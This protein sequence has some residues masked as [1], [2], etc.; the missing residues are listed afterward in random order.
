MGSETSPGPLQ[1]GGG[2]GA[3][4]PAYLGSLPA[5]E[6]SGKLLCLWEPEFLVCKMDA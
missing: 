6:T 3:L 1:A 2:A 4:A 5:C